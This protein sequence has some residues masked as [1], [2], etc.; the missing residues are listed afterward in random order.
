MNENYNSKEEYL[1]DE[2]FNEEDYINEGYEENMDSMDRQTEGQQE[3][4]EYNSEE[5]EFNEQEKDTEPIYEMTLEIEGQSKTIKVYAD[6]N[7][8]ELA[9]EF[10]RENN[11]DISALR[12][13]AGELTNL[14]QKYKGKN[15]DNRIQNDEIVEVDEENN[16]TD[17]LKNGS[18]TSNEQNQY[19]DEYDTY[20]QE[21][22]I[23][24]TD[25]IENN[26]RYV[27]GIEYDD[28]TNQQV[29][30]YN[31][32]NEY[33]HDNTS[34]E[35]NL[36]SG[37]KKEL[38]TETIS[39]GK[40]DDE[41]NDL[42][43]E[44][45]EIQEHTDNN[46]IEE[47]EY[48][49]EKPQKKKAALKKK[50][51]KE[52]H[53]DLDN[54][55]LDVDKFGEFFGEGKFEQRNITNNYDYNKKENI[56]TNDKK[57]ENEPKIVSEEVYVVKNEPTVMPEESDSK[58]KKH[59][60]KGRREG[61]YGEVERET[62][63]ETIDTKEEYKPLS[64]HHENKG[65]KEKDILQSKHNAYSYKTEDYIN[66]DQTEELE[67]F[68]REHGPSL[69]NTEKTI[70]QNETGGERFTQNYDSFKYNSEENFSR[71]E[72]I[73]RQPFTQPKYDTYNYNTEDKYTDEYEREERG[74]NK[75]AKN[76]L[77]RNKA[78]NNVHRQPEVRGREQVDN[79]VSKEELYRRYEARGDNNFAKTDTFK[80][81]IFF[82]E[83][84][85][86]G[87]LSSIKDNS[88]TLHYDY[89]KDTDYLNN[90][91]SSQ[92]SENNDGGR[93]N[94]KLSENSSNS[95]TK[96]QEPNKF[97]RKDIKPRETEQSKKETF[98]DTKEKEIRRQSFDYKESE[99]NIPAETQQFKTMDHEEKLKTEID[100]LPSNYY[101][102][103]Y[104][105]KLISYDYDSMY[106]SSSRGFQPKLFINDLIKEQINK[107]RNNN[108]A[109]TG[110]NS[111]SL[112]LT[113]KSKKMHETM[114][115]KKNIYDRLYEDAGIKRLNSKKIISEINNNIMKTETNT[116]ASKHSSISN[117]LLKF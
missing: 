61:T 4:E 71:N 112:L 104:N 87:L 25:D 3:L 31:T 93:D 81:P 78:D 97:K 101:S 107:N 103:S 20:N 36:N 54:E 39:S 29:S 99:Q 11:L 16:E 45:I 35:G 8:E 57:D 113:T 115:S 75:H 46:N 5:Q 28:D 64:I 82:K 49:E 60:V 70:V 27:Q 12:Y 13:L 43:G 100:Q 38:V 116:I 14:V 34:E 69:Y 19:V 53:L 32:R 18:E 33:D 52:T 10:C 7:P 56:E 91:F 68:S 90:K 80:K 40:V 55:A 79:Y 92:L 96:S 95:N 63:Q 65:N 37:Y 88:N 111:N 67:P 86:M 15:D 17:K 21:E 41:L 26:I 42:A 89:L 50:E 102:K 105:S 114:K 23:N 47:E 94:L 72:T 51:K 24:Q 106:K 48:V 22:I 85:Q 58:Y 62:K 73:E 108:N 44:T 59:I 110:S 84:P 83:E 6:S 66:K 117:Y 2:D 77:K 9:Y 76:G 109:K 98:S 74:N 30:D 1:Y